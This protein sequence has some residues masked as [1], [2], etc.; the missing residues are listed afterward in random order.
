MDY[1][2]VS[3]LSEWVDMGH[4]AQTA[5]IKSMLVASNSG[6]CIKV[7]KIRSRGRQH[8]KKEHSTAEDE[9]RRKK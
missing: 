9:K 7:G 2:W 1:L 3:S 6:R 5:H 4:A 8:K